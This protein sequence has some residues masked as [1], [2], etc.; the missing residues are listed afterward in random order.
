M[1]LRRANPHNTPEEDASRRTST[2][3]AQREEENPQTDKKSGNGTNH[4]FPA[5]LLNAHLTDQD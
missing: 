3:V 5:R 2:L 4:R 1:N